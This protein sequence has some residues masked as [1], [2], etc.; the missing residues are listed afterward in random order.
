MPL[1]QFTRAERNYDNLLMLLTMASVPWEEARQI[2]REFASKDSV[3]DYETS[4]I[5][6]EMAA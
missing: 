3:P 2:A 4:V 5:V 1:P 6:P